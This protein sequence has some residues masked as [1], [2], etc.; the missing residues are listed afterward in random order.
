MQWHHLLIL[1]S[2]FIPARMFDQITNLS[3][4]D[5]HV[6]EHAMLWRKKAQCL[7]YFDTFKEVVHQVDRSTCCGIIVVRPTCIIPTQRLRKKLFQSHNMVLNI[8]ISKHLATEILQYI[9]MRYTRYDVQF[10]F[11]KR[12]NLLFDDTLSRAHLDSS[13]EGK[14]PFPNWLLLMLSSAFVH[15]CHQIRHLR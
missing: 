15:A 12:V 13:R 11:L 8:L 3:R 5:W 4:K 7:A 2:H 6:I 9:M 10:L 1:L 14:R